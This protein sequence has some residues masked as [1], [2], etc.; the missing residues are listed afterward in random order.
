MVFGLCWPIFDLNKD[1]RVQSVWERV[2]SVAG[3]PM[4]P[5]FKF[6]DEPQTAKQL[7]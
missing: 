6:W 4:S 2:I 5:I 3:F 7:E 1:V